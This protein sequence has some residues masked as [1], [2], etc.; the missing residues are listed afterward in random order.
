[1]P[2]KILVTIDLDRPIARINPLIYGHF[3]EHLGTLIYDG[4]W[5]G[6]ESPI[7]N[8]NGIRTDVVEALKKIKPPVM[9]WP[10]GC[11]ADDYHW[12]DGIGPR[13]G[14]PRRLNLHWDG[15]ESNHFGTHEFFELC[16]QL[17]CESYICGNVGSGTVREMRDWIEYMN[18]EQ[19]T[20]LT[21]QRTQNGSP[22][23]LGVFYFGV[24]NENWGC[25]G[26]MS[27]D[28]YANEY[29]RYAT[30]VAAASK[31]VLFKIACGANGDDYDW[32]RGFFT[33][34]TGNQNQTRDR[35]S[36]VNGFA[37]HYYCGTAGTATEY[38]EAQWYQLLAQ[39]LRMEEILLNH[40][41]VMDGFDP[42]RKVWLIVDEW[43]AWHRPLAS[44]NPRWLMQQ[45]TIR[46]ALVAAMTLDIFNRHA[47]IVYMTNIA[48]VV[49]VLQALILT[50]G[51]RIL[52]TPTYHVYEMYAPHQGGQSLPI[53][54][55][56]DSILYSPPTGTSQAGA[57]PHVSG[58]CSRKGSEV[59]LTLVNAHASENAEVTIK[60]R[61]KEALEPR[62]WQTLVA[63]DIHAHN[64]FEKPGEVVLHQQKIESC[65]RL[66]LEPASVH[67]MQC[68]VKK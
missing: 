18:V 56:S 26:N 19:E 5:V 16:A 12:Q 46:D 11:F 54:V 68:Q 3:A 41:K 14:R 24:G 27:P 33:N 2:P 60:W 13:E 51:S 47:D 1:M 43:G 35:L 53:Q 36:M 50:D 9:R 6:P 10:G 55:K 21:Q 25:G 4:F 23:P 59:T 57:V 49:N 22:D 52:M 67:V 58:S 15:V 61:G 48:Q 29:K 31:N 30:Y 7:K 66:V 62:T 28:Y 20:T 40:R 34:I 45:N 42:R 44:T 39:A 8:K 17:G 63:A 37:I 38:T 65:E 64:T 32:T